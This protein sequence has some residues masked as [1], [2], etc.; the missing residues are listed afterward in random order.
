MR[1][2]NLVMSPN[3]LRSRTYR[4]KVVKWQSDCTYIY[5]SENVGW[6]NFLWFGK[7]FW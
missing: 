3:A 6:M 1:L 2:E 7:E 5:E 4:L